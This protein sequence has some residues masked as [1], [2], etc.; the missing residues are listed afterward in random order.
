M[1]LVYLGKLRFRAGKGFVYGLEVGVG[2]E[3]V[4]LILVYFLFRR[5]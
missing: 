3:I 5:F 4:F 1:F 2:L